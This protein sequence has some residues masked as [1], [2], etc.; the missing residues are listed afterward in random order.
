MPVNLISEEELRLALNPHRVD[1]EK[2]EA[3]VLERIK[4]SGEAEYDPLVTMSPLLQSRLPRKS[5][6]APGSSSLRCA[7]RKPRIRNGTASDA[8]IQTCSEVP[9]PHQFVPIS[10][11]R[12]CFTASKLPLS[13][14]QSECAAS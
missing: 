12:A 10:A 14:M 7:V 1:P 11:K 6:V 3:A 13:R 5:R 2:F 4:E 9:R 8:P